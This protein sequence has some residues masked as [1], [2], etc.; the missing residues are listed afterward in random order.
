ME[1]NELFYESK[2]FNAVG[3]GVC[4][5]HRYKL[6]LSLADRCKNGVCTFSLRVE[7]NVKINGRWYFRSYGENNKFIL[8]HFPDVA[9]YV[10]L[11]QHHFDGKISLPVENGI[12]YMKN[13]SKDIVKKLMLISDEEYDL[14]K[15][16]TEEK[17]YFKY[18][19]GSLGIMQ[20]W[21]ELADGF[22]AVIEK[23]TGDKWVN[24]YEG[25][26][27]PFDDTRLGESE[28][29]LIKARVDRG[30]YSETN[31]LTRKE[32]RFQKFLE[33]E[34]DEMIKRYDLKIDEI[35]KEKEIKLSILESGI[36]S[37]NHIFYT[38]SNEVVFNWRDDAEKISEIDFQR[39][40]EKYGSLLF[41]DVKFT[42]KK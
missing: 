25:K 21:K 30:Y 39:Y 31:I 18:L 42:Y 28:L 1:K 35:R 6:I 5:T 3:D 9:P 17:E 10:N 2:W 40:V 27:D 38:F 12:Y 20:N 16:A 41:P 14:L 23:L 8:E 24:P 19:L 26:E 36:I 22:I 29:D 4:G 7:N 32:D 33:K 34:K 37:P 15:L 11:D 13:E